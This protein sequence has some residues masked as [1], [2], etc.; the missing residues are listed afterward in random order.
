M[1]NVQ[2][3]P[4]FYLGE[5]SIQREFVGAHRKEKCQPDIARITLL[6]AGDKLYT[7]FYKDGD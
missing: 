7:V 1:A 5:N 6:G 4:V 2:A 3:A